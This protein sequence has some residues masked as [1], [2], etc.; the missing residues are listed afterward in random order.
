MD[1]IRLNVRSERTTYPVVIGS[2]I[3]ERLGDLLA[4]QGLDRQ[5]IVVSAS[6]VWRSQGHRLDRLMQKKERP[7]LLPDGERAKVLSTV[8]RI[9]DACVRAN[10]DRSAALVAF[11][12]G[13]VGDV[14]GFAAAT[15]LR[16]IALV[17]VP[18]T[19]LA[20][21][22]SAIGGKVGVNLAAGKN[23][24]G[25]FHSP[26]IVV[27]DPNVL[28]TL[29]RREFRSGLYEV[30]KYGVIASRALFERVRDGLNAIFNQDAAYLTPIIA[31]CCRIKAGVVTADEREQGPRRALNFGHTVGHA[32]EAV[33][34]YRRFRHGEAI[35]Y[36]MLAA[37]R[38]SAAR[39][40]MS[41]EDSQQLG[42]LLRH[43]GPLPPVADLKISDALDV[44]GHDKKVVS[45]TLHFVLAHGIGATEIVRDVHSRELVDAMRAI[46]MK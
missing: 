17:Q 36:G 27:C 16:G 30:V 26:A 10:L 37:A 35:G 1:P 34:S 39:G 14:T 40:L 45:G 11:G 19:L 9:Y 44:I 41:R 15:Y 25:A 20:Q 43:M 33:T 6:P 3:L 29:A 2:G 23:L 18:T 5:R 4:E 28:G 12:G 32:L 7:L 22:D 38:L 8:T 21:V 31:E 13:V 42:E 46:G 24:V